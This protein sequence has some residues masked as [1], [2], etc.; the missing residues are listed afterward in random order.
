MSLLSRYPRTS[1]LLACSLIAGSVAGVHPALGAGLL[2]IAGIV[3]C[4]SSSAC[5][6]GANTGSGDGV[7]ASAT[8]A[9]GL[10][11][12]TSAAG[13]T[14]AYGET[15]SASGGYGVHGTNSAAAG[16][17]VYGTGG[18]G[19][20]GLFTNGANGS[21]GVGKVLTFGLHP[22]AIIGGVDDG[23][24]ITSGKFGNPLSVYG[25]DT[26]GNNTGYVL[27]DSTG[28]VNYSG[29]LIGPSATRTGAVV[30][31]YATKATQSNIEDS[32]TA[33]LV[34]GAAVVRLDPLYAQSIDMRTPYRV[35]LTPDGDSHGLYVAQKTPTAF[36][37][38]E[39]QGGHTTLTFDYRILGTAVG[40]G[41][42]R[43]AIVTPAQQ[44]RLA[45]PQAR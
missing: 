39:M 33:Q 2:Q 30:T 34:A 20:G 8:K 24:I 37:V 14:G 7:Q 5:A 26:S 38:R 43:M 31:T 40:H 11:A 44:A 25:Y 3:S 16:F 35:F 19:I 23:A 32:G 21:S 42:D 4:A 41:V 6:G 29:S 18:N 17:G 9:D 36:V 28:N 13:K 12:A 1:A 27:V 45:Y 22:G 15:D 10:R